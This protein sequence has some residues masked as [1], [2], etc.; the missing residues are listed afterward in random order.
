MIDYR[1]LGPLEVSADGR[2]VEIGGPKLRALLAILLL[3]ANQAVPRDALVRDLWGE[4]PPA[5]AQGSLE[6]YVSRLRKA[7]AAASNGPVVVTRP[8]GYC[9]LLRS[10][11]RRVGKE[12]SS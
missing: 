4:H 12:C 11:E 3:R 8:G 5:G 7:L 1:I 9:L 2:P 6:V 10:E